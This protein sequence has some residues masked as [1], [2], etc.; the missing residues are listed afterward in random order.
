[1]EDT[2]FPNDAVGALNWRYGTEIPVNRSTTCSPCPQNTYQDE[3]R[4]EEC[5]PCV[6]LLF[7]QPAGATSCQTFSSMSSMAW[8]IIVGLLPCWVTFHAI[9]THVLHRNREHRTGDVAKRVRE[10]LMDVEHDDLVEAGTIADGHCAVARRVRRLRTISRLT[11]FTAIIQIMPWVPSIFDIRQFAPYARVRTGETRRDRARPLLPS[12]LRIAARRIRY[13]Y[14]FNLLLVL[15][16]CVP[17]WQ[18]PSAV[19]APILSCES[20]MLYNL[21]T[22]TAHWGGGWLL[23][24]EGEVQFNAA[25]LLAVWINSVQTIV[26]TIELILIEL[27]IH[28]ID[29]GLATAGRSHSAARWLRRFGSWLWERCGGGGGGGGGDGGSGAE[30]GEGG[31]DGEGGEG[32]EG[33]VGGEGGGG[34]RD[35]AE[36]AS[37]GSA[38]PPSRGDAEQGEERASW[39]R[40]ELAVVV[41]ATRTTVVAAALLWPL[42]YVQLYYRG[43]TVGHPNEFTPIYVQIEGRA[44]ADGYM[45]IVMTVCLSLQGLASAGYIAIIG[46]LCFRTPDKLGL[47]LLGLVARSQEE[48]DTGYHKFA[49]TAQSLIFGAPT[50]AARGI[51][52]LIGWDENEVRA[53]MSR[54]VQ[55]I[56]DEIAEHGSETDA[57]CLDYVLYRVA[58]TSEIQFQNGWTRDQA[59]SHRGKTLREFC[60]HRRATGARLAEAQVVA[61]RLYT[62]A[63]FHSINNP[64]RTL[65]RH[66]VTKEVLVP[67]RLVEP[68]PLPCTV[69]FLYDGLKRMRAVAEMEGDDEQEGSTAV[70]QPPDPRALRVT[71]PLRRAV[72]LPRRLASVRGNKRPT[73]KGDEGG[74]EA[75]LEDSVSS[76]IHLEARLC[77]LLGVGSRE[78][79]EMPTGKVLW[80]GIKGVRAGSAFLRKGGTELAPMSTTLDLRVAVRYARGVPHALLFML[81]VDSFMQEGADLTFLSAFPQ[82]R[83]FL[84][85]PLTYLSPSGRRHKLTHDGTRYTIVELTPHYPS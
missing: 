9:R 35:G 68:H 3:Y 28:T 49:G 7:P 44:M 75:A 71:G 42:V 17:M 14:H 85:P 51:F 43:S 73:Q 50:D 48:T 16:A 80:R 10:A 24:S 78:S 40:R 58:G 84:Y 76:G 60:R 70:A 23:D 27:A 34:G 61:Q 79:I 18:L 31:R 57:E 83:E 81:R 29:P 22:A 47:G 54:G 38:V 69:A 77:N 66:P 11:I 15:W 37:E 65:A 62:T 5:K 32:G 4:A 6:W 2:V 55:A 13:I 12:Q 63:A 53:R 52:E 20:A 82:E 8:F 30:G 72:E 39:F 56:V 46:V 26:G 45:P 64:L 41:A 25:A 59:S 36:R 21:F 1:M 19:T 33:G 74:H 67:P